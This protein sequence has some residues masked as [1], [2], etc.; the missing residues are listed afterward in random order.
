VI[1]VTVGTQLAFDRMVDVVDQ[2][3]GGQDRTD[4]FVQAGPTTRPPRHLEWAPFLPPAEHR[5]RFDGASVIVAHAGMGTILAA[6]AQAKPL[7]I[8]PR[9]A[10]LGEHRNDHQLATARRFAGRPGIHVAMDERELLDRLDRIDELV[11]GPPISPHAS[12]ELI[13][14]VRMFI[15]EG[16]LPARR[17]PEAEPPIVVTRPVEPARPTAAARSAV[18]ARPA[19]SASPTQP[20]SPAASASP[21]EP[22]RSADRARPAEPARESLTRP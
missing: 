20:A 11:A 17:A 8:M 9:R 4:V 6:L 3:A 1:F 21:A 7:L 22:M 18:A 10:S 15:H 19:A 16:R 14:A 13:E 12:P 5:R 2:W